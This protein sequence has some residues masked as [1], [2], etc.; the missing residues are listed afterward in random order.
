MEC[1]ITELTLFAS[2]LSARTPLHVDLNGWLLKWITCENMEGAQL[3]CVLLW[4][5]WKARSEVV[6]KNS[7]PDPL[8]L[9]P[10]QFPLC[11]ILMMLTLLEIC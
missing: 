5:I 11:M 9:L 3:F 8:G 1:P 2:N 6:F 10:Q 4:A 7:K